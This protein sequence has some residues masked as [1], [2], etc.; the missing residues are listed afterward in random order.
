MST[1]LPAAALLRVDLAAIQ[2]NYRHMQSLAEPRVVHA[3]VVKSDAYGL[4]L[5]PLAKALID[6]GCSFFFVGNLEEGVRLRSA[7]RNVSIAVFRGDLRKYAAVYER[8]GLLPVVNGLDEMRLIRQS[9][10]LLPF[11]LNVDTG[12]TRLGLSPLQVTSLYLDGAFDHLPLTGVMSHLA[13]GAQLGEPINELQRR[14]FESLYLLL[15]PCWGSLVA[16]SGV[17]LGH[18]Y[19][20]DLTRLGSALYGLNDPRIRPN[21]LQPVLRLSAPIVDVRTLCQGEAVGYGATFRAQRCSQIA[22]VG[23]GY[24]H[25][26]PRACGNRMAA[27]IGPFSTP[28]I[29]RV[30]M[31]YLTID[32]TGI[33]EGLCHPGAWVDLLDERFTVDDMADVSGVAAQEIL[34]RLGA[35]CLREYAAVMPAGPA[36]IREAS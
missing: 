5:V 25:G 17:W 27:H 34:L 30:S 7:C 23:M 8:H 31:E 16:S 28:V 9:F 2:A 11:I 29:G 3:A 21:P 12:L 4:G 36:A 22:I 19:H 26:L 33:P 14:R 1:Y 15:R 32:V 20:F 6:A 10:G 35:A 13:C 24:M 18:R